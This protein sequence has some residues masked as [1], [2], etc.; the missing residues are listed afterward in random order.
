MT[1]DILA[2]LLALPDET[3]CELVVGRGPYRLGALK[4]AATRNGP[5]MLTTVEAAKRYG[6]TAGYW[7]DVAKAAGVPKD[8]MWRIPVVLCEEHVAAKMGTRRKRRPW[9]ASG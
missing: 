5:T 4:A 3:P 8:R 2:S 7:R 9:G 6:W 1:A